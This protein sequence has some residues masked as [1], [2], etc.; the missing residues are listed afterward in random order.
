M[1]WITWNTWYCHPL[2]LKQ[3]VTLLLSFVQSE[4]DNEIRFARRY[5]SGLLTSRASGPAQWPTLY[6]IRMSGTVQC[7]TYNYVRTHSLLAM[8]L[9]I[10]ISHYY[11]IFCDQNDCFCIK[12]VAGKILKQLSLLIFTNFIDIN[13]RPLFNIKLYSLLTYLTLLT[14]LNI[15]ILSCN[16]DI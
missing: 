10:V 6:W 2:S 3:D 13:L 16:D 15:F 5:W 4:G 12:E 14:R 7:I 9:Y 1:V 8:Y 11:S